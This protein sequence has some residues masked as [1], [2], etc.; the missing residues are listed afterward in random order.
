MENVS[1]MSKWVLQVLLM[2]FGLNCQKREV[3]GHRVLSSCLVTVLQ[4]PKRIDSLASWG[5]ARAIL[6]RSNWGL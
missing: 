1:N 3:I 5:F 4:V 6:T 2:N